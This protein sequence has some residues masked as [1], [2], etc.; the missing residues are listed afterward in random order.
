MQCV[1]GRERR[2]RN[3]NMKIA[4]D[5]V[6]WW[7]KRRI[8]F[9]LAV[10]AAGLSTI[11]MIETVGGRV[12]PPGEDVMEPLFMFP[13]VVAYAIAANFCYTL[14]WITE[15]AWSHGD[16][17]RTES[18]RQKIYGKGLIFSVLLTLLPGMVA[19]LVWIRAVLK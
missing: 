6:L 17:N 4:W 16:I 3:E 5:A 9:N 13:G 19:I 18:L 15:I 8:M 11:A 10:F 7:E 2:L 14:S 1:G 12:L